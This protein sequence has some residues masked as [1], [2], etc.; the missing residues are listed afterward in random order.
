MFVFTHGMCTLHIAG[1]MTQNR[2]GAD[3]TERQRLL[4]MGGNLIALT[5]LKQQNNLNIEE[6]MRRFHDENFGS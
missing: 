2:N 5:C 1:G 4:E 6:M 3:E